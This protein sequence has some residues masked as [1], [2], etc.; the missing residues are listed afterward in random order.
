MIFQKRCDI[1]EEYIF[2]ETKMSEERKTKGLSSL[3]DIITPFARQSI[4]KR[5]FVEVD[6]IINWDKI[7]GKALS[8]YSLPQKIDFKRDERKNGNLHIQV[9]SGAFALELKHKERFVLEKINT[10]FGY[11]AVSQLTI[12]QNMDLSIERVLEEPLQNLKKNLVSPEEEN[13]INEIT[14]DLK[15]PKLKEVLTKLGYSIL[16]FN[17]KEE[18][19]DEF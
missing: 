11:N 18:R 6:I 3:A 7:V 12:S 5:G 9:V 16:S 4:N 2:E 8:Q 14:Q 1:F 13:Y 19:K 15:N 10:H 17:N